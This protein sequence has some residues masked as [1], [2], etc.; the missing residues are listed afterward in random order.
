[1]ELRILGPLEVV[2]DGRTLDLGGAR[3]RALLAILLLHRNEVVPADRVLEDLYG[4][5]QPATAAKSLQ[6]HVSRLRKALPADR[7]HTRGSG[8]VLETRA[9]EVD[10]DAFARHVDAGRTALEAGDTAEAE[11]SFATGLALWRGTP[12]H[13][14]AYESFAQGEV[15]RLEEERLVCVE[16]LYEARLALGRH[17]ELVGELERLVAEQPHR[18]RLRRALML[19]LYRSGRQGDALAVYRDGRRVLLDELGLEP[20]RQLQEL[21]RAILQQSAELDHLPAAADHWTGPAHEPALSVED[22]TPPARSARKTVTVLFVGVE[23]PTGDG[24][25]LDPEALRPL[26]SRAFEEVRAA[27]ERF[28]GTVDAVAGDGITAVF[29]LPVVHED[30]ALRAVRAADEA[31]RRL[32]RRAG[33]PSLD[34]RLALCTGE[35]VTGGAH[36]TQPQATGAPLTSSARLGR[37]APPGAIVL[38]VRTARLLRGE[39]SVEP[40]DGANG[41][42]SVLEV[43]E[44]TVQPSRFSSPMVGRERERR[45]LFDAFDQAA[46]DRSCQLFTILGPAGVGKSRLVAELAA[47]IG[48]RATVATGRC[49]PYGEGITYWPIVE[50]VKELVASDDADGPDET[51][52]RIRDLL[53]GALEQDAVAERLARTIG[54]TDAVAAVDE[55]SSAVLTLFEAVAARRPLVVV[56]DDIHWGEPTFLDLV[57]HV[58]AWSRGTPI[59]LVC[60]ARPELLDVR[61][62]WSGGKLNAT[63]VLLEPLS[64]TECTRLVGNLVGEAD[65]AEEVGHRIVE[66]ADGNPLFVE[67]ML[68]MLIDD[69][70]LARQDGRWVAVGD[71]A[72]V[73]VPPTI[74]SLLAARLDQLAVDERAVVEAG[75]VEGKVFHTG[76]VE[77]LADGTDV[78]AA[79]AGLGRKELV[80]PADPVFSDERAFRFRHLL[81][82]DAAYE[83]IPKQA[84]AAQHERHAAWLTAKAGARS[85]EYD[86]IVGY[87]LEQAV[88]YRTELGA[89]DDATREIGA[90]A[91]RLLGTAGRRAF[92]RSDGPAGVNLVSR[93]VAMLPPSDPLRV[94]LLP[95]VRAVQGMT[96]LSWAERVLTEAVEAAATS[97]DRRL[98]ATALVQRGFLRLFTGSDVQPRELIDAAD[99]AIAVFDELH[100]ELGLAR[101][102]RLVGQAHYLG[103]RVAA[104]VDAS[105]RALQHVLTAGDLFEEREIVEWLVIALLLGPTPGA[106]AIPRCELLLEQTAGRPLQQAQVLGALAPLLAMAGRSAEADEVL[107]RGS[108]IMEEAGEWIWVVSF[109]RSMVFLWRNDPLTAER[110]LRPG[111]EALKRIGEKS[112]FSSLAHGLANAVYMQGRYDETEELTRECELA[113]RPNDV[114]S[115]ILWRSTRAKV[116]ARR[117][118][119]EAAL[120]LA[121]E[122]VA[123][124][125]DGDFLPAHAGANEDLAKV[126]HMA[127]RPDEAAAA[128]ADSIR[129][130]E[131]KGNTVAAQRA[132]AIL[133]RAPPR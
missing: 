74:Q 31:R 38:D 63:S 33:E 4:A 32:E 64:E 45:R 57:E 67:E 16:S 61:P 97:G 113:C 50:V 75:A 29:G 98:A 30:D 95:N 133:D 44:Q 68:S 120:D 48:D 51:R 17:A 111:Y 34:V 80:R 100:D 77:L 62:G 124:A 118:E 123:I 132:G 106:E 1:M 25:S 126:L 37:A 53:A 59:L 92:L 69:G 103:R 11:A 102:W 110:E 43:S 78:T 107:A 52:E 119:F 20:S 81:I 116:L 35:V 108:R 96:D 6:A 88:R 84:R 114:H 3:Q 22:S 27:V 23:A 28:G 39:V 56:F 117:E 66:A 24:D 115:Q 89:V 12:L 60:V 54:S 104:C 41:A 127:G 101:A 70:L 109:W 91:A 26:T 125:S 5:D 86:E 93:A 129:L 55:S 36:P 15:A 112:H 122:A 90:R 73:P 46:S 2:A 7:I 49:L 82:R 21:E 121:H 40:L 128:L 130:Y 83:S 18:E 76:S 85:V 58:A 87:H 8:Y 65:L 47:E 131:L 94:D 10:A 79:L 71:L 14:V 105:E 42:L 72:E 99:R 13:D 9:D 19:A